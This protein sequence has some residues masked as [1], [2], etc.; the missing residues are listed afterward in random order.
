MTI[1]NVVVLNRVVAVHKSAPLDD[2]VR[3][4]NI[5]L[6]LAVTADNKAKN[7]EDKI[8]SLRAEAG[9][10]RLEAGRML[11]DLRRRVEAEGD[12]WW[13]WQKGKF[14]RSRKDIEK[15]MRL[16]K[17]DDP[18][19]TMA[20]HRSKV[21]DEVKRSRERGAYKEDV[22]SNGAKKPKAEPVKLLPG[23]LLHDDAC[24]DC[25]SEQERWQQSFDNFAGATIALRAY[26]TR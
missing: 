6:E 20:E 25:N 16:A 9:N 12:D 5:K 21:R 19:A 23:E 11:V 26:W 15:L 7:T 8:K 14:A 4:I 24:P 10:H 3:A 13:K 17:A 2:V 1:R 18:E 22:G